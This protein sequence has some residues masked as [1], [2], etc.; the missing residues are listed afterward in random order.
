MIEISYY[1]P[2]DM[3]IIFLYTMYMET[4]TKN[5]V[6]II[7]RYK[8]ELTWDEFA[9]AINRTPNLQRPVTRAQ[10]NNWGIGIGQP[11]YYFL[12]HLENYGDGWVKRFARELL[13]A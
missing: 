10:V 11:Q 2:I 1:K 5:K 7:L 3:A 9:N 4:I 12:T 13:S 8:G 6:E